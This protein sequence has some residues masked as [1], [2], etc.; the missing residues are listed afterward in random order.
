[1]D[2][3]DPFKPVMPRPG[4]PGRCFTHGTIRAG[5]DC[6]HCGATLAANLPTGTG[7]IPTPLAVVCPNCD[8]G[9]P[10]VVHG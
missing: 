1:M 3:T 9:T 7:P 4:E 5:W 2:V 6:R 8:F 10:L